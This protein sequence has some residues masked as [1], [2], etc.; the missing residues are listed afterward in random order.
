MA[1]DTLKTRIIISHMVVIILVSLSIA[2]AGFYFIKKDIID[3]AQEKVKND[4]NAAREVYTQ[5][6]KN[7]ENIIRF[8]V[9]RSEFRVLQNGTA[10]F[11]T[12]AL[13]KA[14]KTLNDIRV[15]EGLDILT[16]TDEKGN[17]IIRSRNPYVIGD[18]QAQNE[19]IA[20]VLTDRKIA[21]GTQVITEDQL[22]KENNELAE[23]AHMW[24]K[25]TEKARPIT[26]NEHT[27]GL[28]IKAAAPL[29]D[30][31]NNFIGV[32]YGGNLLN[33]NYDIVDKVKNVVY[34]GLEYKG[35]D[36]GTVTIFQNDMRISTN[37]KD[38]GD[39]R[40][41]GTRVSAEVFDHVLKKG[42][43]WNGRAFVVNDWYKTAYEPIKNIS[44]ETIGM[45]YVGTLEQPFNDLFINIT[46]TFMIIII[47][48]I[49]LAIFLSVILADRIAR[50]LTEIADAASKLST[51]NLGVKVQSSTNLFE[52]NLLSES[53]NE[54]SA[55]LSER[56]LNLKN[57]NKNYVDLIGFVAHELRGM[58]ASAVMNAYSVRDGYLG[59][60]NFKQRKAVDSV[61]RNLDY[62]TAVVGK[63]LNLG[64]IERDQLNVHKSAINVNDEIFVPSI[65]TLMT[66]AERK[67]I[68]VVNRLTPDL[69]INADTDLMQIVANNL[70]G[71]AIKYGQE[72]GNVIIS[73]HNLNGKVEI[74]VYNDSEP[75][76]AEQ[77]DKLFHRFS[78]LETTQTK[79]VKGTGLGL[80]ITKQIIEQHGGNI[81]IE[82]R[83]KGN[84]FILQIEKGI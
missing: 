29:F 45:L 59:L 73:S 42:L 82:P 5:E 39:N 12:E 30:Y 31:D 14:G 84:S 38:T 15:A 44:G 48:A 67:G 61:T 57:L 72:N 19:I 74:D 62:L 21:Y 6:T 41:I 7:I 75:I 18:N 33:R 58:L 35:K 80:Y 71:N 20:K 36:T 70:I 34:K 47:A 78:R 22:L 66:L 49:L 79:K 63:F 52:L 64:R 83:E 68:K 9:M 65:S 32:L 16:L 37:V 50:P 1:S 10:G 60:I 53:F 40:A 13:H 26:E 3:R 8:S 56:E 69:K 51:G 76:T 27:S 25:Y 55:K 24:V 23:Q 43:P 46:L 81:R 4:L 77:K 11:D 54:M 17:V 28:I 2:V